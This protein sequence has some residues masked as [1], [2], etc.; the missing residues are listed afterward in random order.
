MSSKMHTAGDNRADPHAQKPTEPDQTGDYWLELA[1]DAYTQSESYFEAN[2]RRQTERNLAH[3]NSRHAPGSKYYKPQYKFR[4]KGF[5]PKTRAMVR[6]NESALAKAMFSTSD[7]V[8][9]QAERDFDEG[10]KYSAE[11]NQE[12]LQYRLTETVPWFLTATGAYQDTMVQGVVISYQYWDFD[13]VE[14]H[15]PVF[16]DETGDSVLDQWGDQ[17]VDTE[18]MILRDTPAIDLRPIENI[19]FSVSADWRDPKIGRASC[20]E[21]V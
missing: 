20:R 12:L 11:I 16:D 7:V 3:F 18:R 10:Q 21:R 6:K 19:R 17:A 14:S 1:R 9:V 4:N 13:E 5:R 8:N 15:T 2:I